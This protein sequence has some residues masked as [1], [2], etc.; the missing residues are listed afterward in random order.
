MLYTDGVTEAQNG[1]LTLWGMDRLVGLAQANL[2]RPAGEIQEA[3]LDG[4]RRFMGDS[5]QF[6]D[7]AV[8]VFI[9]ER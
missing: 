7:I 9:R 3:I 2:G 4:V 8:G 1:E 5:P 6:D